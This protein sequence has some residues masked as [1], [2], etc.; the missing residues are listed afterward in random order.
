MEGKDTKLSNDSSNC[1]TRIQY[2]DTDD[3]HVVTFWSG[4]SLLKITPMLFVMLTTIVGNLVLII[5]LTNRRTRR[6]KRVNVFIVNLAIADLTVAFITMTTELL[7]AIF[8]QW[9][10][11]AFLCKFLLYFQVVTLSSTTFLLTGMSIDRYQVIVRPLKSLAQRPKIKAKVVMAWFM[12]FVFAI[13]QVFIFVQVKVYSESKQTYSYHCKSAGYSSE[14]QRKFYF[15]FLTFYILLLPAGIMTFCYRAIA[16]VIWNRGEQSH[17]TALSTF[18]SNRVESPRMS[19]KRNNITASR[20][21]VV[22]M[23]LSVIIVYIVCLTPYFI[24][25]LI[26]IYS[27]YTLDLRNALTISQIIFMLHSALNPILYGLFTLRTA[28][29]SQCYS[30]LLCRKPRRNNH[31]R[32]I[33]RKSHLAALRGRTFFFRRRNNEETSDIIANHAA[34]EESSFKLRNR[35]N[36][37]Y[38]NSFN[39]NYRG[40]E[41]NITAY[42]LTIAKLNGTHL[43]AE[44][45]VIAVE[46]DTT[47]SDI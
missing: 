15:T 3:D 31:R 5:S 30:F 43:S 4:E 29:I 26:R 8:K 25:S 35:Q 20:R 24:I 1:R 16:M 23:T 33:I 14:W 32:S 34:K 28:H 7:E 39:S 19:M 6:R 42:R 45:K 46:S 18:T 36:G 9:I 40:Y 10:L 37:K 41:T 44:H 22:F 11:G 17:D 2:N 38:I 47:S 12:A 21:K 13:P 27:H